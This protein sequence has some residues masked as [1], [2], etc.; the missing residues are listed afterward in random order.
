MMMNVEEEMDCTWKPSP[1]EQACSY[2]HRFKNDPNYKISTG[3]GGRSRHSCDVDDLLPHTRHECP[4]G[5][6]FP[7]KA[8]AR[9]LLVPG[10][11]TLIISVHRSEL[12]EEK[13]RKTEALKAIELRRKTE[14]E[15]KKK[16][17]LA[18]R[19]PASWEAFKAAKNIPDISTASPDSLNS[20]ITNIK[21]FMEWSNNDQPEHKTHLC[22]CD[23]P[24]VECTAS[25]NG[26]RFLGCARGPRSQ[27]GC[28]RFMWIDQLKV[29]SPLFVFLDKS[30]DSI[31]EAKNQ[32]YSSPIPLANA[33]LALDLT[34]DEDDD[35]FAQPLSKKIKAE[36]FD[37]LPVHSFL[38]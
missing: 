5:Q 11:T 2:C 10:L 8:D 18:P 28:G 31:I 21:K 9:K 13:R 16:K 7:L 27:S 37:V 1:T 35:Y 20:T 19:K 26:R 30:K 6:V 22:F 33:K 25:K 36:R 29:L 12:V 38:D 4:M 32:E 14:K 34:V 24:M 15:H 17:T 23:L 3:Q